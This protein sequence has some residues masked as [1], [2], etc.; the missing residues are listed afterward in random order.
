MAEL[1]K[2]SWKVWFPGGKNDPGLILISV[3]SS[4]G[5]YW[6]NSGFS[7]IKYLIQAGKAYL[8]GTRPD[9]SNDKEIHAKVTL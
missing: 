9:V 2:E 3:Q 1:W 8:T 4:A 5:E 6:D 7:G